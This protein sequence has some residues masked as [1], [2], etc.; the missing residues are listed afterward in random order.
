MPTTRTVL[1]KRAVFAA[2]ALTGSFLLTPYAADARSGP[3]VREGSA[4]DVR[5]AMIKVLPD[6]HSG[7]HQRRPR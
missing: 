6:G 2:L 1:A 7:P 4:P 5:P 3:P